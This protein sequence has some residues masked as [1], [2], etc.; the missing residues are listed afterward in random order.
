MLFSALYPPHLGGLENYSYNLAKSLAK[1]GN[2]VIVVT[3]KVDNS[4][5]YE[6]NDNVEV[7]RIP[8]INL[9]NGR[10][11]VFIPSKDW[12]KV[13]KR[14]RLFSP[15]LTVIQARFY[16]FSFFAARFLHKQK[17]PFLIIEHGTSHFTVNNRIWDKLG[18]LYEHAITYGD[19]HYCQD[20]Y[21]VSKSCNAWLKHFNINAKGVLYN[22]IDDLEIQTLLTNPIEDYRK[23]FQLPDNAF[24]ISFTGRLLKEKGVIKLLDAI[25]KIQ[26]TY[27]NVYL[28]IAGEG[29][30]KDVILSKNNPNI[31]L[32][33]RIEFSYVI[34]LLKQ[35][36]VFCLPTDSEGFSTS[37]LEAAA[38]ECFIVSTDAGG[39]KELIIDSNYGIILEENTSEKIIESI[40]HIIEDS[41][42]RKTATTLTRKRL[43]NLFTWYI[44]AKSFQDIISNKSSRN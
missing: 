14:I 2:N 20:F 33:G 18:H 31:I 9:L 34:S 22:A 19:R 10:F 12:S 15:D 7:F 28:F 38:C 4:P 43:Y 1:A 21:G 41:N 37:I 44:V 5:S 40:F 30:L 23:K 39:N 29:P 42:Y 36:D 11:P 17:L 13:K 26:T 3:S 8:C 25:E 24:I 16:T 32:L 35:T 6:I 27:P